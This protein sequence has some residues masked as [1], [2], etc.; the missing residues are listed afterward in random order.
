MQ[1][2]RSEKEKAYGKAERGVN[3]RHDQLGEDQEDD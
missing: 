2:G 3:S 1:L